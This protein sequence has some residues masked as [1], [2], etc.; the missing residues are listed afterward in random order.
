M[1]DQKKATEETPRPLPMWEALA[2]EF[3]AG[4]Y[5]LSDD[6][7]ELEVCY[8]SAPTDHGRMQL[9]GA[10]FQEF[11]RANRSAL[12]ISGGG[13][14]SAT[15]GLGVIQGLA[16]AGLQF[17]PNPDDEPRSPLTEFDF[18]S[19][20]SGGGYVGGWLSAWAA[21]EDGGLQA[22]VQELA[23]DRA[24][25][26]L[27]PEPDALRHLRKYCRFLNPKMGILSADT[28]ALVSTV[29]RNMI[30]N[31]LVLIPLLM[32]VLTIPLWYESLVKHFLPDSWATLTLWIGAACALVATTYVGL[33]IP[34][35][36]RDGKTRL[37]RGTESE[38]VLLAL[39]PFTLSAIFLTL[40]WGVI[41]GNYSRGR[42]ALFGAVVYATGSLIA[43]VV[44]WLKGRT[45]LL[46]GLAGVSVS[47]I[48]GL[49]A[50]LVAYPISQVFM[51]SDWDNPGWYCC[52]AV[53]LVLL[54]YQVA[55][56]LAVGATSK[57][58][59]DDDREWWARSAG[60]V[61][62]VMLVWLVFCSAVILAPGLLQDAASRII[63]AVSTAGVGGVASWLGKSAKTLSGLQAPKGDDGKPKISVT[64]IIAKLAA[65]L[66]LLMLIGVLAMANHSL[67]HM[68]PSFFH[69]LAAMPV[70]GPLVGWLKLP[71]LK[72]FGCAVFYGVALLLVALG[73]S[74]LININRFSL[75]AMYRS[76]LVRTYLGASQ[77]NRRANPF[78]DMD[79]D[80][81]I[82]LVD[83]HKPGDPAKPLHIVNMALNLVG[84]KN[85]A[86][87]QRRAESFTA[88]RLHT[89]SLRVDYQKT[90]GYAQHSA[91]PS[92]ANNGAQHGSFSLGSAIAISG[93]AASPNMGYHSSPLLSLVMTL[94]NARLGWWLA[95]P[96]PIGKGRWQDDGP[97]MSFMPLINEALGRTN[98]ES[99]WVYLS[100]GGH[101]ENLGVYEMVLRRCRTIVVIDGSQDEKYTFE[102]LG[103]AVR[104]ARVDLGVSIT[105]DKMPMHKTLDAS[106]LYCAI[107]TINYRCVDGEHAP[108]GR[109]LYIKACLNGT[110][111]IDVR[112]YAS[113]YSAFPQQGTD[114]L[115]F[116]E[117]QFES[118]RRLGVHIVSRIIES[119][120]TPGDPPVDQLFEAAEN[121]IAGQRAAMAKAA[122]PAAG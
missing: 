113:Q 88:S 114:E 69:W 84:G 94:F 5:T 40:H 19:T 32:A 67:I 101:F 111:P 9:E 25:S 112:H 63:A 109:I 70:V 97:V 108:T 82:D 58:S 4:G 23:P 10:L 76:R 121:Y 95:N 102:D 115:W 33:S 86:W 71:E 44:H 59:G 43:A 38:F 57:I 31:W 6:F 46:V 30:L 87:Q 60:W 122:A 116:D 75:H 17:R 49:G 96:G 73:C 15:F 65:P 50:G 56:I 93:A 2:E 105:F 89:G 91:L 3:V 36:N 12:C 66:F 29:L 54:T 119:P 41:E 7:K 100:D 72:E 8:L 90:A 98:D 47:A 22:V 80:D 61:L 79:E 107:G 48:A 78:I 106:N 68:L 11:H 39:L 27:E 62:I 85:L 18:L 92:R 110:E 53:P 51:Y 103:N 34:S 1:A 13:V 28:W 55:A 37:L 83:L 77:K 14:R 24:R 35:L 104:K 99:R 118:Y 21:R 26:D 45:R 52:V 64:D 74:L 16:E 42:F 20:V 120:H 117:S 81:N